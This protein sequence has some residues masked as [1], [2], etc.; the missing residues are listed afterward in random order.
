MT[1][2]ARRKEKWKRN[3]CK[4]MKKE[5]EENKRGSL[6][7]GMKNRQNNLRRNFV[8]CITKCYFLFTSVNISNFLEDVN[9]TMGTMI[10]Q[11]YKNV[12]RIQS[13]CNTH[14]YILAKRFQSD[15]MAVSI[16]KS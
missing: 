7:V 2:S 12:D 8:T 10:S 1:S 13:S 11:S 9:S 5:M 3:K 14:T 6:F 15:I 16:V 4:E